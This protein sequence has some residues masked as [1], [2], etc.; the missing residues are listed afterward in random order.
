MVDT[1][2]S[3]RVLH[4][5]QPDFKA[6]GTETG[7]SSAS[8]PTIAYQGPGTL[9]DTG[10]RQY[11]W[12]LYHQVGSFPAKSIPDLGQILDVET[13][14][15]ANNLK[16]ALAGIAM[17]VNVAG[18]ASTSTASALPPPISASSSPL[19]P[20]TTPAVIT[21]APAT[22]SSIASSA[23]L[24]STSVPGAVTFVSIQPSSTLAAPVSSLVSSVF[25]ADVSTT[26]VA[27]I[28][29]SLSLPLGTE[30]GNTGSGLASASSAAEIV[31]TTLALQ[32]SSATVSSSIAQS[33][34]GAATL[35]QDM[36]TLCTVPIFVAFAGCI[37][38]I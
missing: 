2:T 27:S 5:L 28:L 32:K 13:F 30:T 22:S 31:S 14:Q 20:I 12:L 15:T 6:D 11:S 4:F 24:I 29:S 35:A 7:I 18:A 23:S 38:W 37:H 1:T 9:K 36:I 8:K 17:A 19:L 34:G 16:P 33:T 21:V 26:A 25:S 3:D 10:T